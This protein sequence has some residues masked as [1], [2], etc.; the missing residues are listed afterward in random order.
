MQ[1]SGVR[2]KTL[3]R[4]ENTKGNRA[5]GV[6]AEIRDGACGLYFVRIVGFEGKGDARC[7]SL[8]SGSPLFPE[9]VRKFDFPEGDVKQDIEIAGK[10]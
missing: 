5:R 3:A 7:E 10:L 9:Q 4:G 8:T 6:L 2:R 1:Y